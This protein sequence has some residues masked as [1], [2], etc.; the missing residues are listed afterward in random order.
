MNNEIITEKQSIYLVIMFILGTTTILIRGIEAKQDL[1]LAIIL[2]VI[3]GLLVSFISARLHSIFPKKDLFD[4]LE[5]C[6]GKFF[7]KM[8]GLLYIWFAFHLSTLVVTDF[9]YFL[10]T[11]ALSE[12]P[13]IAF[14]ILGVIVG[15]YAV[16]LGIEV[17]ARWTKL[18]LPIL[19]CLT[20]LFMLLLIPKMNINNIRP[21]LS[22]GI[23][24]IIRGA[25]SAFSF[26][27]GEIIIFIMVFR[28]FQTKKSPY[29]IY[30]IGLLTSG[31]MILVL[32]IVYVLVLG[33]N[34]A[35]TLY[36]PA[37]L[38]ASRLIIGK[39]FERIEIV[40][41][42]IFI[43]ATFAKLCISLLATCIG[44][45]KI[46]NLGDYRFIVTPI[47]L[48]LINLSYFLHT[49][50]M[51]W[52]EWAIAVWPPFAFLF[53]VI[54]PIIILIIAEIKNNTLKKVT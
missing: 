54:L 36:F 8:I 5:I 32:G 29:N 31:I 22:N 45:S 35:S 51:E 48:L 18:F 12:T 20:I 44:I 52:L 1:W 3:M 49:S 47:G 17:I 38:V 23:E 7:G 10:N 24:P 27:F 46:F 42:V 4:M 13:V 16:K 21:V 37:H 6:F 30:I 9:G 2:A 26:P 19:I 40:I 43:I 53:Q 41:D 50:V 14:N 33:V 11:V 28:N 25:F 15:I 39:Y 34:T